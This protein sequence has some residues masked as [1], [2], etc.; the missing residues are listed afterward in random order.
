MADQSSIEEEHTLGIRATSGRNRVGVSKERKRRLS[1]PNSQGEKAL[2]KRDPIWLVSPKTKIPVFNCCLC[3]LDEVVATPAINVSV[4]ESAYDKDFKLFDVI[5]NSKYVGFIDGALGILAFLAAAINFYVIKYCKL[6]E[7]EKN[8]NFFY[9]SRLFQS[10]NPEEIKNKMG[11]VEHATHSTDDQITYE[12]LQTAAYFYPPDISAVA[13]WRRRFFA[14]SEDKQRINALNLFLK[15]SK[16][17]KID[18]LL[19]EITNKREGIKT[20]DQNLFDQNIDC[21]LEAA[22]YFYHPDLSRLKYWR[23]RFFVSKKKK[24][25]RRSLDIFLNSMHDELNKKI[26][27]QVCNLLNNEIYELLNDENEETDFKYFTTKKNARNNWTIALDEKYKEKFFGYVDH[28]I[29]DNSATTIKKN[30]ERKNNIILPIFSA[31]GQVSFIYWILV[32]LFYFIP[33]TIF[34]PV[35]SSALISLVPVVLSIFVFLPFLLFRKISNANETYNANQVMGKEVIEEQ[36]KAMLEKKLVCLNKQNLY[37]KFTQNKDTV[38]TIKLKDSS[39]LKKLYAVINK[40]RFSKFHAKCMGFLDGC[41]LP[42]FVGWVFLDFIKV[43]LTYVLCPS[44]VALTSFTP[45][46]FLAS[47]VIA[48]VVLLIGISYGICKAREEGKKHDVRFNDLEDKIRAL[49]Q[50]RGDKLILEEDYDR[51]LRRFSSTKPLWT[52]LKK[53]INRCMAVIKRLGTGSLVFRLILWAPM[54][55]V[56]AAIVASTTVP[57]FFPVVLIIG[58]VIGAFALASWYLYAYNIES[59]TTQAQR[60]VEY[61]VQ[62]EQ[63]IEVNQILAS[64]LPEGS[65]NQDVRL[66][67]SK[68]TENFKSE[69]DTEFARKQ[70]LQGIDSTKDE[71]THSEVFN[72][73]TV[74][75]EAR[76]RSNSNSCQQG[77]F[78]VNALVHVE[79]LP[80]LSSATRFS[81]S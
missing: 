24:R 4:I 30:I 79:N 6:R 62:S 42:L 19:R 74:Q 40:R 75:T 7:I 61:F 18:K 58:T 81:M 77:L 29:K 1:G 41:F 55:A 23:R 25:Q 5:N 45:I 68:L 12:H 26:T 53:G 52:D 49:E 56:Y 80:N 46:S 54:M 27:E 67:V 22:A 63:L 34:T 70:S 10:F 31:L 64:S 48:V 17:K 60:I 20:D 39:L 3:S 35:V 51:I 43:F 2:I 14:S 15:N 73:M 28:L 9:F 72:E 71:N 21:Y 59:K 36:H 50:E 47:A 66:E 69:N 38:T 33:I 8:S 11:E 57:T 13:C 65:A 32:F 16:Q 37:V 78:K 44:G 76:Q